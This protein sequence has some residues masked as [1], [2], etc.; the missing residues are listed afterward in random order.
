MQRGSVSRW[1]AKIAHQQRAA[2]LGAV[3]ADDAVDIA[4]AVVE[5]GDRDGVL[6]GGQPVLL[7]VGIDLED[8]GPRAVDGLFP[9]RYKEEVVNL[10]VPQDQ[11]LPKTSTGTGSPAAYGG[12]WLSWQP[13]YQLTILHG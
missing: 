11:R 6:A 10:F 7:G 2:H 5:V 3:Q 1:G 12:V 4:R 8:V 13:D 9:K